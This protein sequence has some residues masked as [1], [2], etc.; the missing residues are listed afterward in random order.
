MLFSSSLAEDLSGFL[1]FKRA[2][3]RKYE[4]EVFRLRSLDRFAAEYLAA[5]KSFDLDRVI[6]DGYPPA[7]GGS[8]APFIAISQSRGNFAC[9]CGD[10]IQDRLFL[11]AI[12]H[13]RR[14]ASR[15]FSRTS[16][17]STKFASCC[18]APNP[19]KG[20]HRFV[21]PLFGPCY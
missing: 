15:G 2:L 8:R 7:T 14:E 6:E 19:L 18:A 10:A 12:S 4:R 13:R 17:R 11:I 5:H 20:R 9:S 3:G 1:A 16:S 21:G